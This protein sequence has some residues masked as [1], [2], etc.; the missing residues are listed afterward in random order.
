MG[1]VFGTGPK[2]LRIARSRRQAAA[3]AREAQAREA[4]RIPE[5]P[6][7][8]MSRTRPAREQPK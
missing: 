1:R 2:A 5:A 3:K 8:R 7:V 4:E 6:P